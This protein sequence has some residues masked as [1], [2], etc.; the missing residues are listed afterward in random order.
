M[1]IQR[2]KSKN[3]KTGKEY[4]SVLL[5]SK[6]R[7]GK[8]VKT[9]TVANLSHLS[10]IIVLGIENM[11]KSD[12][13]STICLKDI[14]VKR[15]ID[16]GYVFV[17]LHFIKQ[18]P[19]NEGKSFP[20][21]HIHIMNIKSWI[22]GIHHHCSEE[23]LKGYL[24]EYHFRFNRRNNMDTIFDVLIR[25]MIYNEPIRLNNRQKITAT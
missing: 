1:Y 21:L 18:V 19:S 20:E 14:A 7:E 10:D 8:K 23:R 16:Y 15:C 13:E 17:L 2:N 4:S 5:C 9:R 11:L 6:Y 25:R 22:Q 3:R 12:G 24:D